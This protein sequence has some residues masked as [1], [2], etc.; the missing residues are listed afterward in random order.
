MLKKEMFLKK[1]G[2]GIKASLC[3]LKAI[4]AVEALENWM[5]LHSPPSLMS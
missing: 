1:K 5:S 2:G 3:K 4:G